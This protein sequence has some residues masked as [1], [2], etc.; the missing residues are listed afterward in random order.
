MDFD[1]SLLVLCW[2]LLMT[3]TGNCSGIS[4]F[5]AEDDMMMKMMREEGKEKIRGRIGK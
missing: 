2:L 1:C 5:R 3:F 4:G